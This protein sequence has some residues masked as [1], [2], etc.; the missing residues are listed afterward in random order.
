MVFTIYVNL[1]INQSKQRIFVDNA[2]CLGNS[3][4][5]YILFNILF[6]SISTH[7]FQFFVNYL[8][9]TEIY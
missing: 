5:S 7:Q 4:S 3:T 8:I 2:Q 6:F 1:Y 9:I